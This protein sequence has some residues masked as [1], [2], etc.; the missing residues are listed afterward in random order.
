VSGVVDRKDG[1]KES[2]VLVNGR[3]KFIHFVWPVTIFIPLVSTVYPIWHASGHII[4]KADHV[5]T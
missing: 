1:M 3:L 4:V 5:I 2:M